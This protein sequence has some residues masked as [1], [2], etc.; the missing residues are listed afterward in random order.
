MQAAL[1][2]SDLE[3]VKKSGSWIWWII[4]ALLL[5]GGGVWGWTM[6]QQS[7]HAESVPTL[8]APQ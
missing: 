4:A 3:P 2:D 5:A 6:M 1:S 8:G 7:Q